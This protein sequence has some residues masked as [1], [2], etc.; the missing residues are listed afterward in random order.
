MNLS[1]FI[2]FSGIDFMIS[3]SPYSEWFTCIYT[4]RYDLVCAQVCMFMCG[5][6]C[7]S[8]KTN[9]GIVIPQA[10]STL[11]FNLLYSYLFL[12]VCMNKCLWG[13]HTC[14][15]SCGG[16]RPV[17]VPYLKYNHLNIWKQGLLIG[18]WADGITDSVPLAGHQ[19]WVLL[20]LLLR[21]G[22][23]ST[24]HHVQLFMRVLLYVKPRSSYL[25]IKDFT[26]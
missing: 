8:Q 18:S 3:Y 10:W 26:K 16:Q 14:M 9:L 24:G 15:Y 6:V 21:Y 7:L 11:V 19:G 2:I 23:T 1:A 22:L 12:F 5:E 17:L 4:F 25:G 13:I 20:F